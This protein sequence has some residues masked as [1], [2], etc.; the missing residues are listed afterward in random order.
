M[1]E[2]QPIPTD[3]LRITEQAL[4]SEEVA[5]SFV[6]AST[7]VRARFLSVLQQQL[8][9]LRETDLELLGR[10]KGELTGRLGLDVELSSREIQHP[11]ETIAARFRDGKL[12]RLPE[13]GESE[14]QTLRPQERRM[15]TL[16]NLYREHIARF[17]DQSVAHLCPDGVLF[18]DLTGGIGIRKYEWRGEHFRQEFKAGTIDELRLLLP[19]LERLSKTWLSRRLSRSQYDEALGFKGNKSA[20]YNEDFAKRRLLEKIRSKLEAWDAIPQE[21]IDK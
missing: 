21:P 17:G 14:V 4:I 12:L 7:E 9:S 10:E 13:V 11:E 19:Q 20:I 8:A 16:I 6:G 5:T 1:T 18:L 2:G 3:W 15:V